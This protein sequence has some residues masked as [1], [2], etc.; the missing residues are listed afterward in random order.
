MSQGNQ[1]GVLTTLKMKMQGLREELEKYKDMY[2]E[3]CAEVDALE[4]KGSEVSRDDFSLK[5]P[6]GSN[7]QVLH[8]VTKT[9]SHF[10]R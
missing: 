1:G 6:A 5:L 2:E 3:K 7:T 8:I 4:R 9:E 10:F